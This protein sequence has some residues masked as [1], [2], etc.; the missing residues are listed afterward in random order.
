[1]ESDKADNSPA[2]EP[3][4]G[5]SEIADIETLQKSLGEERTKSARYLANW[6][7]AQA[8][9]TNYKRL[10]EQEKEEMGKFG[11]SV[12]R[13]GILPILDDLERSLH[14]IPPELYKHAGIE[15]IR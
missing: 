9:L 14:S 4:A 8:D 12:I 10:A 13:S 6:Q 7:K 11:C 15:G 2:S 1:M 3:E 5:V